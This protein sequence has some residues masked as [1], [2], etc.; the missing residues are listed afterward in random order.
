MSTEL[1]DVLKPCVHK[2]DVLLSNT[3]G[4]CEHV[5]EEDYNPLGVEGCEGLMK[6]CFYLGIA[7]DLLLFTCSKHIHSSLSMSCAPV[8]SRG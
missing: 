6:T 1:L 8:I 4:H 3:R 7:Q 2:P 5:E